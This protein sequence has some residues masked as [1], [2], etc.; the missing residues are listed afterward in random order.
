[1]CIVVFTAP[2]GT[3]RGGWNRTLKDPFRTAPSAWFELTNRGTWGIVALSPMTEIFP[4][5][6]RRPPAAAHALV[7]KS[8]NIVQFSILHNSCRTAAN[9][10][11]PFLTPS[12]PRHRGENR[13][14]SFFNRGPGWESVTVPAGAQVVDLT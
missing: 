11:D 3:R 14:A 9:A 2:S 13:S 12:A 8:I 4:S 7:S 6:A 10:L 5:T 1:M